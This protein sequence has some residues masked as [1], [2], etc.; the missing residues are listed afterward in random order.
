MALQS[1]DLFVVQ[2]QNN[3]QLYKLSLN[4]LQAAIEGGGGVNFRG[5]VDLLQPRSGQ[6]NPDPAVNGDMYI[7]EQDAPTINA[8]WTM[9]D[10]VTAAEENDRV[11]YDANDAN[12]ILLKVGTGSGTL[13]EIIGTDPIQVD[14]G[15]DATKP[16]ISIDEATTT[17]P[18]AVHRLAAAADVAASN[19]NPPADA[20]V[21]ADLLKATNKLVEDLTLAPGGVLNVS[22][23][24]T[25]NNDALQISPNTGAVKVEIRTASDANYG[26]VGLADDDAIAAGTA[27]AAHVVDASQL[28]TVSDSIPGTDDFGLLT[29]TEDTTV[30][31]VSGALKI[32][33]VAGD[34]EI[35]VNVNTFCPYDFDSLQDISTAP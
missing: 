33:D 30:D 18:G 6:L 19:N 27:G 23:D 1:T 20:V 16:V 31:T 2:S 8:D 12:W 9:A 3:K 35:G 5:S 7:V 34:V 14:D 15:A 22:S 13:T 28:K 17:L 25:N 21:T 26:V 29:I 4:D 10:G 11:I 32:T 24:D